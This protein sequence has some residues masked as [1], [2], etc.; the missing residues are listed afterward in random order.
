MWID[1][2]VGVLFG[3]FLLVLLTHIRLMRFF[4]GIYLS[5][6]AHFC[7]FGGKYM[8]EFNDVVGAGW[9]GKGTERGEQKS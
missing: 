2:I 9:K 4:V 6:A 3:E 5:L 7:G 8:E 1:C